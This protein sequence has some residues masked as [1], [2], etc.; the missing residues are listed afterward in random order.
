[1]LG[2]KDEHIKKIADAFHKFKDVNGFAKVVKNERSIMTQNG[3]L[4]IQLYVRAEN[5]Q[6]Q[7]NTEELIA[8]DKSRANKVINSSI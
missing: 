7:H 6:P 5:I 3:N 4:S 1:M 8:E 2:L